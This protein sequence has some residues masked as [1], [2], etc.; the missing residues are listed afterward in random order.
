MFPFPLARLYRG[1]LCLSVVAAVVLPLTAAR[2]AVP[3]PAPAALAAPAAGTLATRYA[4]NRADILRAAREAADAGDAG[5]A[6]RLR[7]M[8]ASGRQFL[9]FDGRGGGRVAEVLGDLAHARRVAVL[10]P[11]ADTDLDTYDSLDGTPSAPSPGS[12]RPNASR[13]DH[14]SLGGGALELRRELCRQAPASEVAVVTWLGYDTPRLKSLSILSDARARRAAKSLRGFVGTMHQ[15]VPGARVSLLCHSYGS[16]VC[17]RA[18]AGLDVSSIALFSSPGVDTR[19]LA[20]LHT[21]AMVWVGRGA[22]DWIGHIPHLNITL[23]GGDSIGFGNDP[24]DPRFG[25]HPF[26]AGGGGHSDCFAP[27]S[28]ALRNLAR[29]ALGRPPAAPRA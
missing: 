3:A 20:A 6:A 26:A 25:A 18:A 12:P 27:G 19:N 5:R 23:P 28:P 29:I 8:A 14:R 11:G 10:V 16:V 2:P 1:V 15:I 4:A 17:G 9:T 13:A 24:L 22:Q 21:H 7:R